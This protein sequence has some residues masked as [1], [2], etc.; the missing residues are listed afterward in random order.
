MIVQCVWYFDVDN[1]DNE[2][3]ELCEELTKREL[4]YNLKHNEFSVDDFEI[5]ARPDLESIYCKNEAAQNNNI[6]VAAGI[7][8]LFENYLYKKGI[9][10]D[11]PE[12]KDNECAS[13]IYG[14][15]YFELE[16]SIIEILKKEGIQKDDNI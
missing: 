8:D 14:S 6:E 9:K 11:N 2:S 15:E 10:I 16:N 7:I 12:R 1:T 5:K 4:G 3:N 13:Q